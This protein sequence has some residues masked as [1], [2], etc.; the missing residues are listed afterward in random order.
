MRTNNE[1]K[2]GDLRE[3]IQFLNPTLF[4]DG[5]GGYYSSM[6][7]TY[8]CWAKVTNKSGRRQNSEDQMVIKNQWEIIIRDN[9][10]VTLTKSMHIIYAGQ[11]L[12]IDSIIDALEYDRMIRIIAIERE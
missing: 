9:P 3:R 1:L 12:V 2:A 10:L 4:G 6:G 5:F 8:T 11:T 7:V